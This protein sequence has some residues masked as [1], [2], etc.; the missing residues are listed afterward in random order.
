MLF[1]YAFLDFGDGERRVFDRL[2]DLVGKLF[3]YA[4]AVLFI[5][6]N[7]FEGGILLFLVLKHRV[8]IPVFVRH[9]RLDFAF[10]VDNKTERDG[11]NSSR[12]KPVLYAVV[13]K[14]RKLVTHQPVEYAPCLLRVHEVVIYLA[15]IVKRVLDGGRRNFVELYSVL[16]V[17]VKP[18]HRL[19]M[20]AYRL[21]LAVGVGCE[22]YFARLGSF[23]RKALYD[24]FFGRSDFVFRFEVCRHS[25]SERL[26]G[27]VS[28]VPARSVDFVLA[29]QVFRD[30][31]CL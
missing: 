25:H 28:H 29:L 14:G 18:Q 8:E 3:A 6:V 24:I 10:P 19:Q 12:R 15:R 9:E 23:R 4:F 30:C 2:F 7:G 22:I 5:L 11:L 31:L 27:E 16:A 20:P 26:F 17:F 21:A 1:G 13:Q